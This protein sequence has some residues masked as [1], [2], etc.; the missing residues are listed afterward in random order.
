MSALLLFRNNYFA[1]ILSPCHPPAVTQLSP[2]LHPFP[3]LCCY[4]LTRSMTGVRHPPP[5]VVLPGLRERWAPGGC[6]CASLLRSLPLLLLKMP[7]QLARRR[8]CRVICAAAGPV[9]PPQRHLLT[10]RGV[11]DF[12]PPPCSGGL[13]PAQRIVATSRALANFLSTRS[14]HT[15]QPAPFCPPGAH[16]I[17]RTTQR[18]MAN[19]EAPMANASLRVN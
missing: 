4:P 6:E 3:P 7:L 12:E 9:W 13:A 10:V 16:D 15:G 18:A 1:P 5:T 2:K 17:L 19:D 8:C 11:F 14:C